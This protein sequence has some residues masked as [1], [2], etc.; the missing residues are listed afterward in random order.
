MKGRR[1]TMKFLYFVPVLLIA[2]ILSSCTF[3]KNK[4]EVVETG[5][6]TDRS[7]P[8]APKKIESKDIVS[9]KT[10]FELRMGVWDYGYTFHAEKQP[11]GS[12]L[13]SRSLG[14][15]GTNI[16]VGPEFLVSLQ[17]IIDKYGL[18]G[19]NGVD[20]VTAG[21]PNEP[22]YFSCKYESGES[23]VF[24]MNSDTESEWGREIRDL[25]LPEFPVPES[26]AGAHITRFFIYHYRDG[27]ANEYNYGFDIRRDGDKFT[28]EANFFL[29]EDPY[30]RVEIVWDSEEDQEF[31]A[32]F[33]EQLARVYDENKIFWWQGFDKEDL[34]NDSIMFTMEIQFEDDDRDY[35]EGWFRAQGDGVVPR[36]FEEA[37][38]GFDAL[39][40]DIAD[41]YREKMQ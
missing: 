17:E 8:N 21:L 31:I 11:D 13:L 27:K 4:N 33:F 18:A 25:F 38:A 15:S 32:G 28:M 35:G 23:I 6:V 16:P 19:W 9:F 26:Y 10:R 34:E 1:F 37:A 20:K 12:A 22:T 29:P 7:D 30:E 2:L 3:F 39:V 24:Y 14:D 36:G 5:G 41:A 40:E